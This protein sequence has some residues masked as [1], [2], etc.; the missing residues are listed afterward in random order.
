MFRPRLLSLF[1]PGRFL[2]SSFLRCAFH[3]NYSPFSFQFSF[4]MNPLHHRLLIQLYEL[5]KRMSRKKS[6]FRAGKKVFFGA[7]RE[8]S[9]GVPRFVAAKNSAEG[10]P[11]AGSRRIIRDT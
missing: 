9:A 4:A 11:A 3:R 5:A 8:E 10:P 2:L 6:F 1:L 7:A